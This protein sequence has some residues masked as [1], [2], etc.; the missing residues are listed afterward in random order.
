MSGISS[1]LNDAVRLSQNL[2]RSFAHVKQLSADDEF[3]VEYLVEGIVKDLESLQKIKDKYQDQIP[4]ADDLAQVSTSETVRHNSC[5]DQL[6][7]DLT[8]RAASPQEDTN[9]DPPVASRHDNE[10]PSDCPVAEGA[11]DVIKV[12]AEDIK[13]EA[14]DQGAESDATEDYNEDQLNMADLDAELPSTSNDVRW[15]LQLST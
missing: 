11:R 7:R 9:E 13:V 6:H 15:T 8:S 4:D 2:A 3:E 14:E 10:D 5:S 1:K 12:E